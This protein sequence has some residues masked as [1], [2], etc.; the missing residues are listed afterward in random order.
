MNYAPPSLEVE[1]LSPFARGHQYRPRDTGYDNASV[2]VVHHAVPFRD[3]DA[4]SSIGL[5][6]DD[7]ETSNPDQVGVGLAPGVMSPRQRQDHQ[8]AAVSVSDAL[9]IAIRPGASR[10]AR[11]S[12]GC[13]GR[14]LTAERSAVNGRFGGVY[15]LPQVWCLLRGAEVSACR[16]RAQVP[17]G[18]R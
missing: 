5:S 2:N 7:R 13:D 17:R 12:V 1:E 4:T 9:T 10:D 11:Q 8:R 15:L 16:G 14:P 3:V 6:Q 18:I